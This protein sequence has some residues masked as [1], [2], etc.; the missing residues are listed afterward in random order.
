MQF[1][2][3]TVYSLL[4]PRNRIS[5]NFHFIRWMLN[6]FC[7]L[8]LL[9]I[10]SSVGL[11]YYYFIFFAIKTT[12]SEFIN[13]LLLKCWIKYELNN[14][15]PKPIWM[16]FSFPLKPHKMVLDSTSSRFH[17]DW[18]KCLKTTSDSTDFQLCQFT[19]TITY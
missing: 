18:L 6:Q 16:Y 13:Q 19:H 17:G 4:F 9:C 3:L 1:I 11:K 10:V 5:I 12:S 15:E 14:L 2:A 8:N 7:W